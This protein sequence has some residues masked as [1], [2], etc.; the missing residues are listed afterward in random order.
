[1]PGFLY[2]LACAKIIADKRFAKKS[3]EYDRF[4]MG[5]LIPDL[6]EDYLAAHFEREV[7]AI[8][9]HEIVGVI[10]LKEA[11]KILLKSGDPLHEGVYCHLY[12]E[13]ISVVRAL[14]EKFSDEAVGLDLI[15]NKLVPVDKVFTLPEELP[16]VGIKELDVRRELNWRSEIEKILA[17]RGRVNRNNLKLVRRCLFQT[18]RRFFEEELLPE[19][20]A[21]E[22]FSA[23]A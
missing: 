3:V 15:G 18:A 8:D 14:S 9:I 7:W 22:D 20:S 23:S 21:A 13:D 4:L 17:G 10:N 19:G 1:M 11:K 12:A 2:H 16:K 6:A 5:N